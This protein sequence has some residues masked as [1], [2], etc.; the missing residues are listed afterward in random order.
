MAGK[1]ELNVC[2]R[3][4]PSGLGIFLMLLGAFFLLQEYGFLPKNL[5]VFPLVLIIGGLFLV[6]T[7]V[8]G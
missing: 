1:E 4:R 8:L 5:P 6:I 3:R 7:S 2:C